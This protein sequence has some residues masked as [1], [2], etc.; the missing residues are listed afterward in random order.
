[1]VYMCAGISAH[2]A[3]KVASIIAGSFAAIFIAL[4]LLARLFARFPQSEG[5]SEFLGLIPCQRYIEPFRHR[6]ILSIA[7]R[8][9]LLIPPAI[10]VAGTDVYVATKVAAVLVAAFAALLFAVHVLPRLAA[11]LHQSDCQSFEGFIHCRRCT[12]PVWH[13]KTLSIIN[14]AQW[15]VLLFVLLLPIPLGMFVAS[16]LY[17]RHTCSLEE[18]VQNTLHDASLLDRAR[19]ADLKHIPTQFLCL[20]T[21]WAPWEVCDCE[22][23]DQGRERVAELLGTNSSSCRSKQ[24][25]D[26]TLSCDVLGPES[27]TSF[28]PLQD[29]AA[30]APQTT[31][32]EAPRTAAPRSAAPV[33]A[34]APSDIATKGPYSAMPSQSESPLQAPV[35]VMPSK[36]D[37]VLATPAPTT[38]QTTPP[39]PMAPSS[40]PETATAAQTLGSKIPSRYP[41]AMPHKTLPP[42]ITFPPINQTDPIEEQKV[43]ES[44]SH[45]KIVGGCLA[46]LLML[47]FFSVAVI[48]C[49]KRSSARKQSIN[50]R[51]QAEVYNPTTFNFFWRLALCCD[52]CVSGRQTTVLSWRVV[53]GKSILMH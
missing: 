36:P 24:S 9:L 38:A 5:P 22:K 3:T 26:C 31:P 45:W 37:S 51:K 18:E 35:V 48:V 13:H 28:A 32:E 39:A 23:G 20:A 11:K 41:Q 27:G 19:E 47:A 33:N 10:L 14:R 44:N 42:E 43:E 46:S 25:Q 34:Q 15:T 52:L 50:A 4:H 40:T 53:L 29:A 2:D 12:R 30:G 49:V 21:T 8:T 7:G 6:R 17:A 1:M 16:P